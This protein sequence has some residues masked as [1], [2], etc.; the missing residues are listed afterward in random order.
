MYKSIRKNS[1]SLVP[2][3]I[4]LNTYNAIRTEREK[5]GRNTDGPVAE[6]NMNATI[7]SNFR[8]IREGAIRSTVSGQMRILCT[9]A[10]PVMG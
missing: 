8:L 6:L 9:I 7:N 4:I 2:S 5:I 1:L 10:I 3:S